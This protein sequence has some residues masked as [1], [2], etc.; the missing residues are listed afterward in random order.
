MQPL[1]RRPVGHVGG[2][3]HPGSPSQ[4]DRRESQRGH[5]Q[6]GIKLASSALA[7][8]GSGWGEAAI[9]KAGVQVGEAGISR[10]QVSMA[11]L[12]GDGAVGGGSWPSPEFREMFFDIWGGCRNAR[13]FEIFGGVER[14]AKNREISRNISIS[15][16]LT[17]CDL[18]FTISG[19]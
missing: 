9:V 14:N 2:K 13:N 7:E 8:G 10:E 16:D 15:I 17:K 4:R 3:L 18:L 6:T 1:P 19:I 12:E 5:H 11:R